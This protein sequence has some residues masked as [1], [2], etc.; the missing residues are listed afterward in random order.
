[1]GKPVISQ[2]INYFDDYPVWKIE[3]TDATYYP[4]LVIDT[5]NYWFNGD[6]IINAHSYKKLYKKGITEHHWYSSDSNIYCNQEPYNYNQNVPC[7]YLRQVD[8]SI[9]RWDKL[10]NKDTLLYDYN[11]QIGDTIPYHPDLVV[12]GID[13]ILVEDHYR[14]TFDLG[15]NQFIEGIG[16]HY[17]FLDEPLYLMMDFSHIL[18]CFSLD[19]IS[20]YPE[21][22]LECNVPVG[23][24]EIQ[25]NYA[26][27]YPN[28]ANSI[29]SIKSKPGSK[30]NKLIIYNTGMKKMA[31][32]NSTCQVDISSLPKGLYIVQITY[33]SLLPVIEKFVKF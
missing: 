21:I 17:G 14:K 5:Y 22:G 9:I 19:G 11:L 15:G 24:H 26:L 8:Q 13:S 28:P 18:H 6:T 3:A 20:Y 16:H 2:T 30:I 12:L 27:I 25:N 31:E 7:A 4:C 32:I 10:Q 23:I 1:M 33:E 29:F